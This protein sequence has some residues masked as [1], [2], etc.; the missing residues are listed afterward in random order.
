MLW[1]DDLWR[2]LIYTFDACFAHL[3]YILL[4]LE[5]LFRQKAF[6]GRWGDDGCVQALCVHGVGGV[7]AQLLGGGGGALV[8]LCSGLV[9]SRSGGSGGR[10]VVV[11]AKGCI[12]LM[13][14]MGG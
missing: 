3:V 5:F 11:R 6:C 2:H 13:Q 14:W 7:G 12:C 1:I 4:M 10:R 9:S 8:V